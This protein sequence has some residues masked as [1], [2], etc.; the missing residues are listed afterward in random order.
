[1]YYMLNIRLHLKSAVDSEEKL[2]CMYH[3]MFKKVNTYKCPRD[4]C[5]FHYLCFCHRLIS[6]MFYVKDDIMN[7]FSHY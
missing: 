7:C 1:M 2:P 4:K 5:P 6:L 3:S